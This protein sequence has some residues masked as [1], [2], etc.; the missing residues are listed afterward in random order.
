MGRK[1]KAKNLLPEDVSAVYDS[2]GGNIR[3]TAKQLGISRSSVRRKLTPLAKIEKPFAAGTIHGIKTEKFPLPAPGKVNR[4]ILTSAQNNT[5]VHDDA[6]RN[7]L[8]FAKH[9]DATI[10]VGTYTYNQ[11]AYGKLSV[12]LGKD[13]N[14]QHTLWYDPKVTEHIEDRRIELANGLVWLSL[15]HI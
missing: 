15:I 13:K 14:K 9:Y 8:A 10:L 12:K 3:A 6:W 2:K 4:Y 11:N 5:Y 1:M 7:I